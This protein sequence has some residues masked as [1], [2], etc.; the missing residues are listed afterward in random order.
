MLRVRALGPCTIGGFHTLRSGEVCDVPAERRDQVERLRN[1]GRLELLEMPT[2]VEPSGNDT[3]VDVDSNSAAPAALTAEE[4][5]ELAAL[6]AALGDEKAAEPAEPADAQPAG[7]A[8]PKKPPFVCVCGKTAQEHA[9]GKARLDESFCGGL[10][11]FM[12]R[13]EAAADAAA[14]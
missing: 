13:A 8:K 1:V 6:E 5:A 10:K 11:K 2:A 9:A 7:P 4:Q 3:P 12:K 14:P